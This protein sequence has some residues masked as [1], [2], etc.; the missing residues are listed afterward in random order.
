MLWSL[1]KMVVFFCAV[2]GLTLGAAY[3]L[4]FDG[5]LRISIGTM[6]FNLG[7]LQAVILVLLLLLAFWILLKVV[8]FLFATFHFLN[9]DETA[10]S[11][12]FDRNREKRGYQ[13]LNDAMV[14]LASGEGREAMREASK[15]E[16]LLD[17]PQIAGLLTAQAAEMSGDTKRAEAAYKTMLTD[18]RT[19]FVGVRGI[20]KQR[21]ADGDTD[22][23]MKLAEKAFALKPRHVETQDTLLRLQATKEDWAGARKT[24]CCVGIVRSQRLLGRRRRHQSTRR[25]HRGQPPIAGPCAS[26]RYGSARLHRK[27]ITALCSTRDQKGL[28]IH[29][30]SG[31]G[32][33]ICR[34]RPGRDTNGTHQAVQGIGQAAPKASRNQDAAS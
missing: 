29:A 3:L 15:A 4:D 27:R 10:I 30:A 17:Q 5:G 33:G 21:L 19:R 25:I 22:T 7:A 2:A 34:N 8:G 20:L 12:Y 11:R 14:A 24:R 13:A 28:G 23:A 32:S 31:P 18:D 9:G 26:G 6:E 1:L 16:R